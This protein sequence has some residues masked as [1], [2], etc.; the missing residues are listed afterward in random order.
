M[1][2]ECDQAVGLD[3]FLRF[4]QDRPCPSKTSSASAVFSACAPPEGTERVRAAGS[5]AGPHGRLGRPSSWVIVLSAAVMGV[6]LALQ[7][8]P[9]APAGV[10][11]R[12]RAV[13]LL[14]DG[15]TWPLPANNAASGFSN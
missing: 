12:A 4:W 11:R 10:V 13:L 2:L 14:A 15:H 6:L 7:R 3:I 8:K 5:V 9:T 1:E